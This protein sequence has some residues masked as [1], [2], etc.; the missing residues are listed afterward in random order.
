MAEGLKASSSLQEFYLDYNQITDKGAE[1]VASGLKANSSL[2]VLDLSGNMITDKGAKA[3]K[4]CSEKL[5][6]CSEELAFSP[7]VRAHVS[8]SSFKVALHG[9]PCA[10][11]I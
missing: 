11:S 3:L 7:A 4:I 9:T 6:V 10:E 5:K 1:A 2:Q 8:G